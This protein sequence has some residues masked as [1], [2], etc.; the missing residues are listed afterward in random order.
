MTLTGLPAPSDVQGRPAVAV[1]I[2][3][4]PQA[5]PQSGLNAADIVFD[6]L[7]EGGLS[8]L[9]AVYQSQT[10]P[11]IGPIRSARPVDADLLPLFGSPVFAYSGAARGEIAP[12]KDHGGATLI[13]NDDDPRPFHRDPSRRAPS[14]VYASF[15]TLLAEGRR[16]GNNAAAPTSS[17]FVF[18]PYSGGTPAATIAVTIGKLSSN[19]WQWDATTGQWQ[20]DQD[21]THDVTTDGGRVTATNVV[22]LT[23]NIRGTGIFDASHSEDP[24][25]EVLGSGDAWVAR[26]GKVT[27]GTWSRA[28]IH[29]PF[30]LSDATGGTMALAPGRTWVELV[31]TAQAPPRISPPATT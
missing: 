1:K 7:V 13:S 31:P 21:G 27:R 2:D 16:L 11:L 15:G 4:A 26:D 30:T 23:T 22:A 19:T 9:F 5:R 29:D 14:N 10:A 8:R 20:R 17:P 28:G 6:T 12:V 25:V 3:N 24:F 18:G